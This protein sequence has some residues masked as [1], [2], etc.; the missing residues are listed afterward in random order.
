MRLLVR[1]VAT[2]VVV[3]AAASVIGC[4]RS[5]IERVHTQT[6]WTKQV[7][8]RS[9]YA[10]WQWTLHESRAEQSGAQQR[11]ATKQR[12]PCWR[13]NN[14]VEVQTLCTEEYGCTAHNFSGKLF[15]PHSTGTR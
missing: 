13:I 3:V 10:F 12:A 6:Q 1:A 4:E 7:D 9:R 15:S 14:A 5:P 11:A 8:K 2:D